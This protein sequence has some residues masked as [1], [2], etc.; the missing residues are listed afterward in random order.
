MP[1]FMRFKRRGRGNA[2][3]LFLY[4]IPLKL[5]KGKAERVASMFTF[6]YSVL[7][8]FFALDLPEFLF[9]I[10]KHEWRKTSK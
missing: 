5:A 2:S 1:F 4:C 9:K 6:C 7:F 10:T 3:S 8:N